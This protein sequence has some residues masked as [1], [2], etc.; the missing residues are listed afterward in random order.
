MK[1]VSKPTTDAYADGWDRIF[2]KKPDPLTTPTAGQLR[3]NEDL[4]QV[5]VF[6]NGRWV[7]VPP[8]ATEQ[9]PKAE[10]PAEIAKLVSNVLTPAQL[11]QEIIQATEIEKAWV[12]AQA[13][14]TEDAKRRAADAIRALW[15][16]HCRTLQ[17]NLPTPTFAEWY[18]Q[19]SQQL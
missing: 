4:T 10:V 15:W 7:N 3:P 14:I 6:L 9:V 18:E 12:A 5:Q 17:K 2:G 11:A 13:K 19:Y 16:E 1:I 8:A